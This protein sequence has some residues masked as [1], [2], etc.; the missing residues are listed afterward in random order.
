MCYD[1]DEV[2]SYSLDD[3]KRE[4]KIKCKPKSMNPQ[5]NE[6]EEQNELKLKGYSEE[7]TKLKIEKQQLMSEL[8]AVKT[9][10]QQQE[11]LIGKHREQ[12]TVLLAKQSKQDK[13]IN[14]VQ[15][16]ISEND[17]LKTA[18]KNVIAQTRNLKEENQNLV[19]VNQRLEDKIKKLEAEVLTIKSQ[20]TGLL[21]SENVNLKKEAQTMK[22]QLENFKSKLQKQEILIKN[23]REHI[24]SLLACKNKDTVASN[25]KKIIRDSTFKDFTIN[26]G[27][28]SFKV[29][30][31]L[32][33]AHSSTLAEIFKTN[34]DAQE[35]NLCDI[36]E[37]TFKAVHNFIYNEQLPDNVN[38]FEV[39]AAAA[40]LKI[41]NL[42]KIVSTHILANINEE[43]A[44][45]ILTIGNKFDQ[46]NLRKKA[47]ETIQDK[48]FPDRKLNE[49]LAKQPEKLKKL[50]DSAQAL[51]ELKKQFEQNFEELS[52]DD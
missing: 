50:I 46:D 21:I 22:S 13:K 19:A 8:K 36:P 24:T 1:S 35:L 44:F 49:K 2:N 18:N 10:N 42:V 48:I 14:K 15:Y 47:F 38:H 52:N 25:L 12:I 16:L 17:N 51:N 41:D 26:V 33:A 45:E 20:N 27:K 9:L 5:I 32:F 7:L 31:M 6:T 39:F 4:I 34:P 3:I 29:H 43:N 37:S 30:K 28:S 23:Q 11:T 40:K